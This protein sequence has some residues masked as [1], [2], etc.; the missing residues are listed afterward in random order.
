VEHSSQTT[1]HH[2]AQSSDAT[3]IFFQLLFCSVQC[4]QLNSVLLSCRV[5]KMTSNFAVINKVHYSIA[6]IVMVCCDTLYPTVETVDDTLEVI[7]AKARYWSSI[8]IF[9]FRRPR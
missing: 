8:K 7:D 2:L 4:I 5:L 6:V 1:R 3:N 9:P